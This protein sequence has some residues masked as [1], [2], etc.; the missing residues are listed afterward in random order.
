M[1]G[2]CEHGNETSSSVKDTKFLC[3]FKDY[4]FLKNS[5]TISELCTVVS[6]LILLI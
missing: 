5:T 6:S 1:A 2:S 4:Q 3:Q